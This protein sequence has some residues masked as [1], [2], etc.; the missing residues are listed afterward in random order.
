MRN[1]AGAPGSP[2]DLPLTMH[3]TEA[4]IDLVDAVA[5]KRVN[6]SSPAANAGNVTR[7][8]MMIAG[9]N[10]ATLQASGNPV[11]LLVAPDQGHSAD[12]RCRRPMRSWPGSSS[13]P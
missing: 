3:L 12:R 10:V 7:P 6:D 9:A 2:G 13:T 11:S 8:L 4:G 5:M 1:A